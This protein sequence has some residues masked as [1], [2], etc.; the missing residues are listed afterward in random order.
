MFKQSLINLFNVTQLDHE[1]DNI[2]ALKFSKILSSQDVIFLFTYVQ[3]YGSHYY[4]HVDFTNGI[5]KLEECISKLQIVYKCSNIVVCGDLNSRTAS[6]QPIDESHMLSKYLD[7]YS[8]S[9]LIDTDIVYNRRSEDKLINNFGHRLLEMCGSLNLV[10]LN[11]F[12]DGD[13]EGSFTNITHNGNSVVDYFIVSD[14]LVNNVDMSVKNEIYSSHMPIVLYFNVNTTNYAPENVDHSSLNNTF[15][16]YIWMNDKVDTFIDYFKL[17]ETSKS[18][19]ELIDTMY[20]NLNACI[21]NF[22]SIILDASQSML[23][24]FY[25]NRKKNQNEW[26]DYECFESRK[27]VKINLKLYRKKIGTLVQNSNM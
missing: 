9:P 11:G 12:T 7:D 17:E 27:R 2:I 3:P 21:S 6:V 15:T 13:K 1:F 18:I 4:D 22:N 25:C 5:D 24:T 26:Y 16:K 20:I 10:I 8:S 14:S 23:K 19:V